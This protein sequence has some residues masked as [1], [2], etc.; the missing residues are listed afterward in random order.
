MC[1]IVLSLFDFPGPSFL[2]FL[3]SYV[4]LIV[5]LSLFLLFFFKFSFLVCLFVSLS[6]SVN[7]LRMLS[8][9]GFLPLIV[10]Y[11]LFVNLFVNLFVSFLLLSLM[12]CL[13]IPAYVVVC[14]FFFL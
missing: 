7:V 6:S 2:F 11:F 13:F 12:V 10:V 3:P 4:S 8:F 5:F 1:L 9:V 14:L